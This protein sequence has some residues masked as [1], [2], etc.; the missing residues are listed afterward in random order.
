MGNAWTNE[1]RAK[2]IA[3]AWKDEAFCKRLIDNPKETLREFG[4]E[5]PEN[6]DLTVVQE[7]PNRLYFVLPQ[8]P[9][10]ALNLS[11]A[12]LDKLAAAGYDFK[13][14]FKCVSG[15]GATCAKDFCP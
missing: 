14:F 4:V 7:E 3:R 13:S 1:I 10:K 8:P 15:W 9:A 11:D 12:E 6:V 5:I 2:V